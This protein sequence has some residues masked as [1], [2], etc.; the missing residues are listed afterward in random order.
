MA[1]AAV[2]RSGPLLEEAP[3]AVDNESDIT[4]KIPHMQ[5][6]EME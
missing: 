1:Y 6:Q 3:E 2:D 5:I 4:P